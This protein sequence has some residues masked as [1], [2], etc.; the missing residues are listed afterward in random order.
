MFAN[1]PIFPCPL[2][3]RWAWESAPK[4]EKEML[5]YSPQHALASDPVSFLGSHLSTKP[6][7]RQL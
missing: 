3:T 6:P 2:W 4:G 7:V 5:C 1:L